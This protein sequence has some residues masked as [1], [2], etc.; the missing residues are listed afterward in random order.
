MKSLF[1]IFILLV[2]VDAFSQKTVFPEH[3]SKTNIARLQTGDSLV[4]YQCHVD[5]ASQEITLSNGKKIK[6]KKKRI[7]LTEKFVI[8]K[9]DSAFTCKYFNSSITNYPN[10]KFPY[11]TLTEVKNWEFELKQTKDLTPE[12]VKLI[13]AFETKTHSIVHYE[14]NINKTCPNEIIII[15]KN[16]NEQFIIEGNYLLSKSLNCL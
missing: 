1:F 11:L 2:S 12:E 3:L 8:H 4:Y 16:V 6:S 10:K 13:A 7:T 9:R 15:G 14:L 5:S